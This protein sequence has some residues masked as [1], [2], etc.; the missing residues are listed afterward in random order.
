M[1]QFIE[2]GVPCK[3]H[4]GGCCGLKQL[5]RSG[6][7]DTDRTDAYE[8]TKGGGNKHDP[9]ILFCAYH[10]IAFMIGAKVARG[11]AARCDGD[12][13]DVATGTPNGASVSETSLTPSSESLTWFARSTS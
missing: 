1:K 2:Y 4:D 11:G 3:D 12:D 10:P 8:G 9:E 5:E 7:A 6:A 13:D